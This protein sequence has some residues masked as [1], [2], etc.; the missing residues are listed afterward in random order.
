MTHEMMHAWPVVQPACVIRPADMGVSSPIIDVQICDNVALFRHQDGTF[1]E[2]GQGIL[3]TVAAEDALVDAVDVQSNGRE[4]LARYADGRVRMWGEFL[5]ADIPMPTDLTDVVQIHLNRSWALALR[6]DGTVVT[7]GSNHGDQCVV[8]DAATNIVQIAVGMR[9]VVALRHDGTVVT[10]GRKGRKQAVVRDV[11]TSL[12]PIQQ[13]YAG[14]HESAI[15][16]PNGMLTVWGIYDADQPEVPAGL[17]PVTQV[18]MGMGAT[19]ALTAD[20][21]VIVWGRSWLPETEPQVI[22]LQASMPVLRCHVPAQLGRVVRVVTGDTSSDIYWRSSNALAMAIMESGSVVIWRPQPMPYTIPATIPAGAHFHASLGGMLAISPNGQVQLW[23]N[24]RMA[25]NPY[26][27]EV[28][29][30]RDDIAHMAM[31]LLDPVLGRDGTLLVTIMTDDGHRIFSYT[32]IA[33]IIPMMHEVYARKTDGRVVLIDPYKDEAEQVVAGLTDVVHLATDPQLGHFLVAVRRD[34]TVVLQDLID[35]H[36]PSTVLTGFDDVWTAAV[37][38]HGSVIGVRHDGSVVLHHGKWDLHVPVPADAVDVV[39]VYTIQDTYMALRRDGRVVA[40]GVSRSGWCAVPA[41]LTDV[42]QLAGRVYGYM[43]AVRRD[44]TLVTWGN[45]VVTDV[46][47]M[48]RRGHI[49][50]RT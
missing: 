39:Q 47:L 38:E 29:A 1:T 19:V 44:G 28:V 3:A 34:G 11:P 15:V 21:Q 30:T 43:V 46:P 25:A 2:L 42:H 17:P 27:A 6:R 24:D 18:A 50:R 9:H 35:A 8:P 7:W 37:N 4:L 31:E 20:Q 5:D 49:T 40:W 36:A 33:Q 45:D 32:D 26:Y 13:L 10:W 12:P 16:S 41:D 48:M 22:E 23:P 14:L